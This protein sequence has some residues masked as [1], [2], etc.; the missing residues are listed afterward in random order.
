MTATG[1][2]LTGSS[3]NNYQLFQPS[4]LTANITPK[5]VTVQGVVALDKPYDATTTA[6]PNLSSAALTGAFAGDS[7]GFSGGSASGAFPRQTHVGT[8]LSV[9]ARASP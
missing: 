2:T 8:D 3:T 7:I 5:P 6:T 4:G 9:L 1:F